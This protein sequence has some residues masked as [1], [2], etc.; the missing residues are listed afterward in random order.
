MLIRIQAMGMEQ[1]VRSDSISVA[2]I[3][4]SIF[5]L[6]AEIKALKKGS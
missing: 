4:D 3:P 2:P 1:I 5:A 6:P